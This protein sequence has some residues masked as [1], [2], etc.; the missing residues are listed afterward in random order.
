MD[1]TLNITDGDLPKVSDLLWLIE[2]MGREAYMAWS[3]RICAEKGQP[4]TQEDVE[5]LGAIHWH[6][7]SEA[8]RAM[9][10]QEYLD[11]ASQPVIGGVK[12]EPFESHRRAPTPDED[13]IILES[14]FWTLEQTLALS[15]FLFQLE[16][17]NVSGKPLSREKM[18]QR[19]MAKLVP[20]VLGWRS[21]MAL[22][23]KVCSIRW[24]VKVEPLED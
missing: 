4:P 6:Y 9:V 2:R 24:P 11:D 15:T 3:E 12:T 21:H 8:F 13:L 20:R 1:Q 16:A 17:E 5:D 7:G 10:E 19:A 23:T 22:Y 18:T 14:S